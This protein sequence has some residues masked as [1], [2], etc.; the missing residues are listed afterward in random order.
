R[1]GL[2]IGFR[3]PLLDGRALIARIENPAD[4]FE[5]GAVPRIAPQ[6]ETL[7]LAGHGLR[8]MSHIPALGGYL[9]ISGPVAKEQTQFHLW[10]WSGRPGERPRHATV[11]GLPGFEHAEGVAPAVI[12]GRQKIVI[13]SDDGDREAGRPARYLLIDPEQIQIAE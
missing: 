4:I 8:G 2:L 7:D 10:F 5:S 9:L 11:L 13:V 6:L 1:P 3:S 12:D